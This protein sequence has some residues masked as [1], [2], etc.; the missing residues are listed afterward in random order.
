M[1]L[2]PAFFG[3][4]A[5]WQSIACRRRTPHADCRPTGPQVNLNYRCRSHSQLQWCSLAALG[6]PSLPHQCPPR[7]PFFFF[8]LRTIHQLEG[9]QDDQE[10]SWQN[11]WACREPII[12]LIEP[13]HKSNLNIVIALISRTQ[14]LTEN[15]LYIQMCIASTPL[16]SFNPLC[17]QMHQHG[18]N[19]SCMQWMPFSP[20]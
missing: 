12:K 20:F 3:F 7:R 1:W 8:E 6:W 11:G 15:L 14:G 10:I 19:E 13:I 9:L 16:L 4:S 5:M 18:Q 2:R 17:I